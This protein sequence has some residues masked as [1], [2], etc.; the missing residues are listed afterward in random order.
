M[1][2]DRIP[3]LLLPGMICDAAAWR[4]QVRDLADIAAPS[5]VN[6]GARDSFDAMADHVLAH[7]PPRFALAGHSMGGRVAQVVYFRAPERVERLALLATDFRGHLSDTER[8]AEEAR[9]D[10]M[11]AKV[12]AQG[13]E[14]FAR[15]WAKT[16]LAPASLNDPA[17][18]DDVVAMM[19]RQ[20]PDMLAAHTL[21]AL[22]RGDHT[23]MLPS[24]SV[25]TL[26]GAGDADLLRPVA[27]HREM[28]ARIPGSHMVVLE[29]CGHMLAME[30]PSET[31]AALRAW[32]GA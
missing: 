14:A 7:A 8:A 30:R 22:S 20:S 12:R 10:G 31:T 23:A 15:D 24:I 6:F 17:L 29:N 5:V 25:P 16:I 21:A 28:A 27:V 2:S 4:H 9:R 18:V 26:I 11:L 19:V 1:V 3:L 32:L 13:M